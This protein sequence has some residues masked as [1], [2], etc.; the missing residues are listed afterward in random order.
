[1]F[2]Y[3]PFAT[4]IHFKDS[5]VQKLRRVIT[6][7]PLS[8]RQ[9]CILESLSKEN[10]EKD[11]IIDDL[12]GKKINRGDIK[13]ALESLMNFEYVENYQKGGI[14]RFIEKIPEKGK[15]PVQMVFHPFN[16]LFKVDMFK[17]TQKG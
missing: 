3:C 6:Q 16:K 7:E 4:N 17:L 2:V 8:P 15:R 5:E 14:K 11:D 10:K 1:M 12:Q 13:L 9:F